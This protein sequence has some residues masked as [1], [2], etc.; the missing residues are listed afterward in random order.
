[1]GLDLSRRD[2]ELVPVEGWVTGLRFDDRLVY[3]WYG[4]DERDKDCVAARPG[5]LFTFASEDDCRTEAKER[6]WPPADADDGVVEVTDLRPAQDW[7]RGK[8]ATL[9][10]QS[11]LDLWNW[12][13]D[14]AHSAGRPWTDSSG[15][16]KS[17]YDKLFAASVPW[18]FKKESYSPIWSP[19]QLRAI[20][21]V[22]GEAIHLLRTTTQD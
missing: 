22:L 9:N 5:R 18:V 14:V 20:R 16:R 7:L 4:P 8:R 15:V 1:M 12:G 10:S 19:R 11:A 6:G 13:G 3:L 17:C 2:A 21:E